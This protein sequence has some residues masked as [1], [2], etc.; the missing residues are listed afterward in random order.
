MS[1]DVCAVVVTHD[2][3]E[4]LRGCLRALAGQTTQCHILVVDN[5]SNDGTREWLAT[6][7]VETL[8]LDH[9]SGGAGGFN[10]GMKA[11]LQAGHQALWLMDDDCEPHPDALEELLRA[12][13]T[14]QEAHIDFGWL[15]AVALWTDGTPC[16]MNRQHVHPDCRDRFELLASALLR[17]DMA[18]F[19]S[20]YVPRH[21]VARYGLPIKEFFIWSDDLEWTRRV[22][23]RGGEPCFLVGRSR[24]THNM[25]SNNGSNIAT[26]DPERIPRYKLAYRN[27]GYMWRQE[28]LWGC[29]HYVLR[30]GLHVLRILAHA[31]GQRLKRLATLA[32]GMWASLFF[33]PTVEKPFRQ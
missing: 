32:Q 5:A 4:R 33:H 19:V 27:E 25:S 2:R 20:L 16:K 17:V 29:T 3:L 9:N 10:A 13:R 21:T 30:C 24:A 11:A 12:E 31:P 22:A 26:D 28:G 15:S 1:P 18:T 7:N 14:L 6:Q 8:T 23:V